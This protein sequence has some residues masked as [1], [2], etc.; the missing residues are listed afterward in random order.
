M[1][2]KKDAEAPTTLKP[3]IFPRH[4]HFEDTSVVVDHVVAMYPKAPKYMI[5]F[6]AG[7]NHVVNYQ[8]Q[9]GW[10]LGFCY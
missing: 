10:G 7:A 3:M 1:Q 6:S 8:V 5:G 9:G 2:G 4:N